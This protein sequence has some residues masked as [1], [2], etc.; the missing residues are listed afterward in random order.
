MNLPANILTASQQ[1]EPLTFTLQVDSSQID[2]LIERTKDP[3]R[4]DK[5][6]DME[7]WIKDPDNLKVQFCT[8]DPVEIQHIFQC[9]GVGPDATY[10]E[11]ESAFRTASFLLNSCALSSALAPQALIGEAAQSYAR[12][13]LAFRLLSSPNIRKHFVDTLL[14]NAR[15]R[16]P[17]F[18][19]QATAACRY[20]GG[21]LQSGAGKGFQQLT[22]AIE[23]ARERRRNRP[24]APGPDPKD[25]APKCRKQ[26]HTPKTKPH[27]QTEKTAK[28]A[29]TNPQSSP[30]VGAKLWK[31]SRRVALISTL[32]AGFT[33]G[34][35]KN[36]TQIDTAIIG[37][38]ITP[39]VL[40]HAQQAADWWNASALKQHIKATSEEACKWLMKRSERLKSPGEV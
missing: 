18:G 21:L 25:K 3:A 39:A 37:S 9:L 40:L 27:N 5:F 8:S 1:S 32:L 34:Y 7:K 6:L 16:G 24:V 23:K 17:S 2:R 15:E 38:P 10:G 20:F 14:E 30:S 19:T 22:D 4:R 36:K 31:V 11:I 29:V 33:F 13:E 35:K 28:P 12:I 26:P